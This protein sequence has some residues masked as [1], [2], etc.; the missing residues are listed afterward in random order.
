MTP[1]DKPRRPH[2]EVSV[3]TDQKSVSKMCKQ[4][5]RCGDFG[6]HTRVFCSA[7]ADQGGCMSGECSIAYLVCNRLL[8]M[9]Q[10]DNHLKSGTVGRSCNDTAFRQMIPTAGSSTLAM[11]KTLRMSRRPGHMDDCAPLPLRLSREG[12][13]ILCKVG[14]RHLRCVFSPQLRAP[15]QCNDQTNCWCHPVRPGEVAPAGGL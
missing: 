11:S 13:A 8:F 12:V 2:I 1:G 15:H 10:D 3:E 9:Q 6:T 5:R 4:R 14:R 7:I